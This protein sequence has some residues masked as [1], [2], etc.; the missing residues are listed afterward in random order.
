MIASHLSL[1]SKLHKQ[2][3]HQTFLGLNTLSYEVAS[4]VGLN[5]PTAKKPEREG[6]YFSFFISL[7]QFILIR[8]LGTF[9]K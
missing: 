2:F 4:H 7:S 8:I 9:K 6:C 5:L 1:E 3:Y